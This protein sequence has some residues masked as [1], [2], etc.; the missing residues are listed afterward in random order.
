[1][2][3]WKQ[4]ENSV[5][6][7]LLHR[8]AKKVDCLIVR[9]SRKM[10][11]KKSKAPTMRNCEQPEN[12]Y[13]F[14]GPDATAQEKVG[15]LMIETSRKSQHIKNQAGTFLKGLKTRFPVSVKSHFL[16]SAPVQCAY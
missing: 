1:M 15:F 14:A 13:T 10:T 2:R 3:N 5:A 6:L 7:M 9:T 8:K 12:S 16:K 11:L 4:P